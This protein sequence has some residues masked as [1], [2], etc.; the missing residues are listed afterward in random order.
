MNLVPI[1][2]LKAISDEQLAY[3]CCFKGKTTNNLNEGRRR[4]AIAIFK[5]MREG[6][7]VKGTFLKMHDSGE[8]FEKF[9]SEVNPVMEIMGAKCR[10]QSVATIKVTEVYALT[11]PF[12]GERLA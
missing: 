12:A 8:L 3:A 7:Q 1:N 11:I 2:S 4:V 10:V 5:P 6:Y 9:S